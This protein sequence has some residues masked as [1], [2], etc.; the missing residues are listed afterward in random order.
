[1]E[2]IN[3]ATE[4]VIINLPVDTEDTIIEKYNLL[5]EVQP[6][7]NSANLQERIKVLQRFAE[8]FVV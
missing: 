3:P 5:Q 1:M 4:E 8:L 6:T 7:W 2:I